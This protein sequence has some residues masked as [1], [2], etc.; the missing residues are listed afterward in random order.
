MP[1]GFIQST[2]PLDRSCCVIRF[3]SQSVAS[4]HLTN[5][6]VSIPDPRCP[7]DRPGDRDGM[8]PL[9]LSISGSWDIIR[10]QLP[11]QMCREFGWKAATGEGGEEGR[12]LLSGDVS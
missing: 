5:E 1:W 9:A 12:S 4:G 7:W 11:E 6:Q 8:F 2:L 10:S 3:R